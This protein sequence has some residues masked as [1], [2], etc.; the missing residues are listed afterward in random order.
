MNKIKQ[1]IVAMTMLMSITLAP[2]SVFVG[3][4][5]AQNVNCTGSSKTFLGFP[6]WYKYLDFQEGSEDC[7][8]EFN[9]ATDISKIL[10]AVFEILL[11]VAGLVA[12]GFV[13]FGGFQYILSQGEPEQVKGAKSTIIN[14]IIGLVIAISATAV[15]NLIARNIV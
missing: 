9:F 11:R 1:F 13:L 15:V 6:T 14:A 2:A 5:S 12:I 8:I 4:A 3:Q 7:E 10:L